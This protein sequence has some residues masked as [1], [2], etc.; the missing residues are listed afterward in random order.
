MEKLADLFDPFIQEIMASEEYKELDYYKKELEKDAYLEDLIVTVKELQQEEVKTGKS[1]KA[2]RDL[3]EELN[4]Y[5][6]YKEYTRSLT[7][8]N[9]KLM[10]YEDIIQKYFDNLQY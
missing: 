3:K 9:E 8:F 1:V 5:P 6:L 2:L 4:K 10:L 7:A